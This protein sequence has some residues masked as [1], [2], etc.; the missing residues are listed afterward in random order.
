MLIKKLISSIRKWKKA[1]EDAVI[2]DDVLTA[3]S[4]MYT[5]PFHRHDYVS[6]IRKATGQ[7]LELV[8]G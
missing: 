1:K 2:F 3:V 7:E 8:E 5:I 6:Q 4:M